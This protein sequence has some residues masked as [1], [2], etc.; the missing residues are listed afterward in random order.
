MAAIVDA[1]P[2]TIQ[3]S[4]ATKERLQ[5]LKVGGLTF[6]DVVGQLLQGIDEEEFR[7]IAL[8]WEAE[9]AKRIRANPRNVRL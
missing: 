4:D 1:M 7:R 3:L 5:R 2:T 8:D 6:D 9:M